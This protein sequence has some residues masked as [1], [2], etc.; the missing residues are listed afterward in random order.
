MSIHLLENQI[1]YHPDWDLRFSEYGIEI[2]IVDDRAFLVFSELKKQHPN[3]TYS[4]PSIIP[5]LTK[6]DLLLVHNKDFVEKLFGSGEELRNEMLSCY[7]L[8]DNDGLYHRYHPTN[9]KKDLPVALETILKQGGATYFSTL[10]ALKIGFSYYLGGGMHHAMSFG[11]RGFCL[12]NDIVIALK[13]LQKD[14]LIKT[15]WVI[16]IDAHKGDGTAELTFHDQSIITLSVHM[17]SGWPLDSEDPSDPCFTPSTLDVEIEEGCEGA[18]LDRLTEALVQLEKNYAL[19]Q[20]AIIVDGADAYEFDELPS[21]TKLKLTREQMLARNILVYEFLKKK[22]IPQ[23]YVMAG[24]YGKKSWE[25]YTQF[26]KFVGEDSSK[27]SEVCS[28]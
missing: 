28:R 19:P 6:N 7:E 25:I 24:G 20:I 27:R 21:T 4:D 15:A 14:K 13:K 23:S 17:K 22:G 2:P 10:S 3:L 1:F 11:G 18:Y 12:I 8:I 16:D 26:L 5:P 9:A